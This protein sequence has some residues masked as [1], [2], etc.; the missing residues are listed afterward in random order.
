MLIRCIHVRKVAAQ[1]PRVVVLEL[2]ANDGLRALPITEMR[3][4][5]ARMLTLSRQSDRQVLL[6]GIRMPPNYGPRFTSEFDQMY[7][8]LARQHKVPVVP[9]FLERVALRADLM[10]ADG[11]HPNA[12][13]QPLV[14]ENV[15]PALSRL[16]KK[17][18]SQR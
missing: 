4:N 7:L 10:Q 12:A 15:W 13:G 5:L 16:L 11:L 3:G 14:L 8:D 18:S 6:L 9:F 1:R 2:G 17:S